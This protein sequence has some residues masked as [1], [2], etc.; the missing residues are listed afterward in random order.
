MPN[1]TVDFSVR[2]SG[3]KAPQWT[4]D[5]DINGEM[6]LAD[7]LAFTK[8]NLL[9][10]ADTALAEEQAKGFDKNPV[11][12]V[13]GRIGKPV[14]AVNPLG[15]IMFT[16]TADIS[17]VVLEI[18][19]FILERS[20]VLT[21]RYKSSHYV[22]LN[23]KQVATDLSS[24]NSWLATKPEVE[25]KDVIRFVNI[26]PYARKLE[27]LGVTVDRTQARFR[28]SSDK[29]Q[30]SGPQVRAPNGTYYL[31]TRAALRKF[32][33]NLKI[34]FKFISGS[35]MGLTATFKMNYARPGKLT[36]RKPAKPSTYLYPSILLKISDGGVK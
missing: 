17:E 3:R 20:P 9:V 1:I 30:R 13:D 31:A 25:P 6:T 2:E 16:S 33:Q 19:Q 4:L 14:I 22:F 35:E 7:L 5:S 15:S 8:Q 34:S 24:L 12:T 28:K 23:G 10:I 32:K 21:G 27:R 11:V 36:N 18:Y 26:Q 29:R